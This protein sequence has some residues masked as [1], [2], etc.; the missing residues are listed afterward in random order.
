V[1]HWAKRD[2]FDSLLSSAAKRSHCLLLC[3]LNAGFSQSWQWPLREAV[4]QDPG[5]F[6]HAL[7]GP[8]ASWISEATLAE[9][10]RLLPA[11]AYARLWLNQWGSGSG[12]AIDPADLDA[13]IHST[14]TATAGRITHPHREYIYTLGVDLGLKHDATALVTVGRHVGYCETIHRPTPARPNDVVAAML[15]LGFIEPSAGSADD[16]EYRYHDATGRYAVA[17][18]RLWKPQQGTVSLVEIEQAI[19]RLHELYRFVSIGVDPWQA[20]MLS[21][22]LRAAGLPVE[23]VDFTGPSLKAMATVTLEAFVSRSI[24]LPEHEQLL[25][26]LR[27]LRVVE[28]S[29]GVRLDSPRGGDGHGDAATAMALA[30]LV[31]SR[32]TGVGR[33]QRVDGPL[34]CWP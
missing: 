31:A 25:T 28:K 26:D 17:D 15:D 11:I 1:T 30:L 6:F 18:V 27:G 2:L 19:K 33:Q 21:E 29:Y 23:L 12:D 20:R 7:D 22:R 8:Q 24:D 16:V 5:W 10:R 3:I 32:A 14:A 9:Q 34:L 13:A 4:R